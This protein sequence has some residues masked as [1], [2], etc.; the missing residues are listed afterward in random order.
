M[1]IIGFGIDLEP[2]DRFDSR[3]SK[4][5][6][7]LIKRFL[8]EREYAD[9]Q[10]ITSQPSRVRFLT[11]H[12]CAKE[13]VYKALQQKDLYLDQIEISRLPNGHLA[14]QPQ[15]MDVE[16]FLSLTYSEGH[17]AAA[18]VLM[19]KEKQPTPA[20]SHP[21]TCFSQAEQQRLELSAACQSQVHYDPIANLLK[22]KLDSVLEKLEDIQPKKPETP[23][24]PSLKFGRV[25]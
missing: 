18:C 9:Y 1:K 5:N 24:I 17:C 6:D 11:S 2:L 7:Y 12:W 3:V 8:T 10:K 14:Y 25:G 21:L 22:A 15:H 16:G 4:I 20:S 23:I 13:A 19:K